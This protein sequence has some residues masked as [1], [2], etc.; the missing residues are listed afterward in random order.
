[1]ADK[2]IER[3]KP[4]VWDPEK[5]SY[6]D[7]RFLVEMWSTAW[8]K[9]KLAKGDRGYM[10]FQ[11][12]KDI[13]KDNIGN[14]L[15]TEA[16]LG[17][18]DV[19]KENCVEQI[20]TVLD[21]RFK[22]DDL[23]IKKK[24]WN[25]FVNLK[26]GKEQ[27]ID[28]FI[29]KFDE[30][31]SNLRKAG[32]AL[33][34]ETYALQLMESSNL[35]EDLS[36][37]V[38]SGIND[39]QPEIFE[40]TK[41]AMR[42]YLGSDKSGLSVTT[43]EQKVKNEV[44]V[45]E[46]YDQQEAYYVPSRNFNQ[47]GRRG[48]YRGAGRGRGNGD[49]R[50]SSGAGSAQQQQQT[51]NYKNQRQQRRRQLN[52]PGSDGKPQTCHICGSIFHFAGKNGENCPE[53]YENLQNVYQTDFD[54]A[55]KCEVL[56][57]IYAVGDSSDECL[58]DSCC[59]FNVM[60]Q[61]WKDKFFDNFSQADLKEVKV[62]KTSTRYRFGGEA[63]I[64]ANERVIF[65]CYILGE[66]TTLTADV[67]P[68]DVPF[69]MSKAEM[70]ARG[71]KIDFDTD[72]LTVKGKCHEL[73]TTYNGHFKLPLWKDEEVN[74]CI[75]DMTHDE[76]K[77]MITKLHR[78][79]RHQPA[80][81]T[82]GLMRRAEILTPELKKLNIEIAV[83]CDICKLYKRSPPRPVVA[84]PIA[85][86]FNDVVAMDLKVF[87]LKN[88]VYFIHY[89][90]L[91]TRFSKASVIKSKEPKVIVDSF[92]NTWIASGL[93]APNK[94]LVDNGGEFD[95]P[96]LLEAME[97]FNIEVCATAAYSPWSNGTCERNHA[98]VDL[99]VNKMLEESQKLKLN[100][101]LAHA[102]N[103]K[104]SLQN[105]N[106]FAPIQLVTGALPNLPNVLNSELPALE[107]PTSPELEN[108]LSAMHSA[109]RA[110]MKAE[111]SEKIKRAI[112]HP[113]R[114]CEQMY[115]N[116]D[117]VFYKR[118]DSQ[119]W[120]GPGKVLGHLGSIVYVIH[121]SRLVRCASCRVIKVAASNIRDEQISEGDLQQ[122]RPD[123]QPRPDERLQADDNEPTRP[124]RQ[125]KAPSKFIPEDGVWQDEEA[126]VVFIPK[127]RHNEPGVV[128]AKHDEIDNWKRLE[129]VDVV[130]DKNQRVISTRWVVT[131]KTYPDGS[132]KPKARLV[133]RGFEEEEEVQVDAP[134]AAKMTLRTVLAI[135]ANRQWSVKTIDIKAAFLQGRA[136]E[137]DIYLMPP[138]EAKLQGKLWRLRKSAY[139]LA[140]A[141]RNWYISVRDTLVKLKC[142]QSHLDKAVFRWY[143]NDKIEGIL[144]LHVDDFL[145]TGTE[146]FYQ[147]VMEVLGEKF[148]VGSRQEGKFKYVGL[149]I[150]TTTDGIEISQ[151]QYAE[152]ISEVEIEAYERPNDERLMPR[153]LRDLRGIIGQIQWVSSQTRPDLSFDALDLS[154]GRNKAT[155]STLKR[156]RKVVN[157]LKSSSST[158]KMKAIGQNP[159]LCVY[160]DAGF[161]NLSDGV[162]STQGFVILLEGSLNSTVI[163]WGSRKI[164][165]KVS[166]TIEAETLSLKE[167]TNNAIY[168][169]C[170]LS[171]FLFNDF[172][173]N[174]IPVQV[175]TDNKPLEQS[176]RS[177]KQVQERRLRVDIGEVQRLIEEK[178][179]GDIKWIPSEDMLGDGLTKRDKNCEKLRKFLI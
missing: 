62:E 99:M 28:T 85:S 149:N 33:D 14:K 56:Q 167:T 90:D 10:L 161:C 24:A 6:N 70:K 148:Q 137:R 79:F 93:G 114:S 145:V 19:F 45:S 52:P 81:V 98:V 46:D 160:P 95:N 133:V 162:S 115:Q 72:S 68:R 107:P 129:A 175:F 69:L 176:I 34:D 103:A 124:K 166:S 163:D 43:T 49:Q 1:M 122:Q 26:R 50:R 101:A 132:V 40:Q 29:D 73:D 157:K 4:P 171:E 57:E 144:V 142:K 3:L 47:R 31:C 159:K 113:V 109:R 127:E 123:E 131:E 35:T 80:Y 150:V 120:K 174:R 134:T 61:P 82:E 143:H 44:F 173:N 121:G 65:P 27:D 7:W 22:E 59:T 58:L 11:T 170:L 16:Q 135:A 5:Q 100:I 37:L 41:R 83:N 126:N 130:D 20:L 177:T 18:I 54:E 15:I 146:R 96:E 110:F 140:D 64:L 158:I 138:D 78:Q 117:K 42:K 36:H 141:A 71:F 172:T 39:K 94:V 13:T 108:H 112:R 153:E 156:A 92:I 75:S 89:I 116:G 53:S 23:A 106:G 38:I 88:G 168:I 77:A 164:K 111:S 179:I 25:R 30:A 76:K 147:C 74:L 139:G 136:I 118:E 178:E 32:R 55:L 84:L 154:V 9:A 102:I 48:G 119:R 91:F 51:T 152:E 63:P 67:V 17:N 2:K 66:R 21:K 104:N 97:Q 165:R 60:G 128:K 12:L 86:K 87:S 151:N 155:L 105:H 169:G 125:C 8:E